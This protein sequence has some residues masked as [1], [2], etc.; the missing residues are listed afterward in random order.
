M[1]KESSKDDIELHVIMTTK[2]TKILFGR[3]HD[4]SERHH[5]INKYH[6]LYPFSAC[7]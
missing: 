2:I 5:Y 1:C 4:I 6:V 3:L 7:I